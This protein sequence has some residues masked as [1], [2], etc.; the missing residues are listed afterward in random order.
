MPMQGSLA[1]CPRTGRMPDQRAAT[2]CAMTTF[3]AAA[4][5][6]LVVPTSAQ[7]QTWPAYG[8]DPG[9]SHYSAARQL[10]PDNV[11]GLK[12]LWTFHT[13]E[14]GEGLARRDKLTFEATPILVG[15]TLYFNTATAIVFAVDAVTGRELWRYDAHIDRGRRYSEMAARGVAAWGP[16]GPAI[17][18]CRTRIF[19]GTID[20]RLIALDA[21]TGRLC[22]DFAEHGVVDLSRGVR[23]RE[24]GEYLV[25]SPPAV[26]G[27]AVVVGSAIGDNRGTS[28]E[29]GVVRAFDA[30][31]GAL[32][33][34]WDPIPRAATIPADAANPAFGDVENQTARWTGAANAWSIF[35]AAPAQGLVFVPTGSAS[36]DFYGGE[37]S[38]DNQWADSVVA[39][40]AAT[41]RLVWGRQ[42]VHHDLWDYD[43]AAQPVVVDLNRGSGAVP[44]VLQVTKTG[45]LYVLER[46]TGLAVFPIEERPVP[47]GAV[48]GEQ[49]SPTQP[50][51]ALPPLVSH[52]PVR[53]EDAWGLTFWD[54]GKCADR[55]RELRSD[56]IF[57][58]PSVA[59][60]IERPGYGGGANW[61][62]L[63]FDPRHQYAIAVVNDLPMVVALI[64]RDAF[65]AV[66]ESGEYPHSEFAAMRGTPY[67]MR[68]EMLRSPLGLPCVAPPWGALVAVDLVH[69][70]I[71][72]R[73]PLGTMRDLAWPLGFI[74]GGPSIGGPIVT[75]GGLVFVGA[76]PDDYLRAFEAASGAELWK[77]RLPGGGQATPMTYELDGRQFV[78]IAAGGHG[79]LGTTRGDA[80]VAFGL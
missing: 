66:R 46:D 64:P 54:R 44:V 30:R 16:P 55:I 40:D 9:G 57:T 14:R 70:R 59:G 1:V 20:A 35:S 19:A 51:S 49:A 50:R 73:V 31:S 29:L 33:W 12:P 5:L 47:Q 60:T 13:G 2:T 38:G 75:A 76:A 17:E 48:D 65:D 28:L 32:R 6:A 69:G 72:W 52:D 42:L 27:D 45:E 11:A 67:G 78:V 53:A 24:R 10:T 74:R 58:P 21:R 43:V 80:L 7:A 4:G 41:G 15:R 71:A 62:G 39:L 68:R 56:G 22:A 26:V 23:L 63:A 34:S 77:G 36:P 79:G 3:A 61:G 25:T 37:R 18:A 8:G